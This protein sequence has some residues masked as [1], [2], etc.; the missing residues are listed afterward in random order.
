MVK[1]KREPKR[2]AMKPAMY[3]GFAAHR[4]GADT[5]LAAQMRSFLAGY[6]NGSPLLH[7]LYDHVLDEAVPARLK[8]L[9]KR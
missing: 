6:D 1:R 4:D 8:A 9:L 3:S 7:A 5:T 2:A